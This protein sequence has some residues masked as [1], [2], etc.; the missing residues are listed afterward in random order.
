VETFM[1]RRV[2]VT[3]LTLGALV[4]APLV[5]ARSADPLD[6]DK[7]KAAIA[8][9]VEWLKARQAQDG[10]FPVE[11]KGGGK[12][13]IG[14]GEA[15]N[16]E[17]TTALALLTLLKCGVKPDD[18][19]INKGFDWLM[20]QEPRRT[21]SV[22]ITILAIEARF[23]P[24]PDQIE[25]EKKRPYETIARERFGKIARPEDKK[26]LD[27]LVKWLLAQQQASVW[28]YPSREATENQDNS[29][30]QYA[31]MALKSASRLG[32]EIPPEAWKK[33]AQYFC[34][35]QDPS[36]PEVAWFPVPAAD[37]AI[38]AQKE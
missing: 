8:K 22:A 28:R 21:Y 23:Q 1:R 4:L 2:L 27:D 7:V 11:E 29:C 36:G 31:V 16:P 6:P 3:T 18:P 26:W 24:T 34:E 38:A 5:P 25:K 9:G 35:Q 20:Q 37:G 19:A 12:D 17:G 30:T 32:C 13:P 15:S 10:T 33:V 14:H